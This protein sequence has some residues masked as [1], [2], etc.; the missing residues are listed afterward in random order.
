MLVWDRFS[1]T[2]QRFFLLIRIINGTV[3]NLSLKDEKQPGLSFIK[4][5]F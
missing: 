5:R 3:N 2:L 1:A 4:K